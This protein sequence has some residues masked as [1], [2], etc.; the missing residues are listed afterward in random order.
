VVVLQV[1]PICH[2]DPSTRSPYD[3]DSTMCPYCKPTNKVKPPGC[4]YSYSTTVYIIYRGRFEENKIFGLWRP[5]AENSRAQRTQLPRLCPRR[6]WRSIIFFAHGRFEILGKYPKT[7]KTT[8]FWVRLMDFWPE[9]PASGVGVEKR[10]SG[11]FRASGNQKSTFPHIR[12]QFPRPGEC[13]A[14]FF[15]VQNAPY[16]IYQ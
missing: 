10:I 12:E 1:A 4:Y 9:S 14:N 6:R 7:P 2:S 5:G 8:C 3:S 15:Y 13:P 11:F 16:Y